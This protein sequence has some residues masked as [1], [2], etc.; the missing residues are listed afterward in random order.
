MAKLMVWCYREFIIVESHQDRLIWLSSSHSTDVFVKKGHRKFL[1]SI[2]QIVR[3]EQKPLQW[4]TNKELMLY[5]TMHK[6]E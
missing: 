4:E 5:I 6:L 2:R 1:S 3:I